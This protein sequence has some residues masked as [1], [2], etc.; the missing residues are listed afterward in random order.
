MTAS[1]QRR[2]RLLV[3]SAIGLTTA[4]LLASRYLVPAPVEAI[5]VR[6][7]T[8]TRIYRA[9]G[10]L[11]ADR[12][13][14]LAARTTGLVRAAAREGSQ[15]AA[16]QAVV[17]LDAIDAE[18]R[19]RAAEADASGGQF[20]L[21]EAR[22]AVAAAQARHS[23]VA[24]DLG[25]KRALSARGF[26]PDASLLDSQAAEAVARMEVLRAQATVARM[27][28]HMRASRF[29]AS[30][31]RA[32][33]GQFTLRSPISGIVIKQSR[34][35]GEIATP[36]SAILEIVDPG[37]LAARLNCDAS[38]VASLR[39]GQ[40]ARLGWTPFRTNLPAVIDDIGRHVD[41]ETGEV[42]VRV[43]LLRPPTHWAIGQ[44]VFAQL[45][46]V[47]ARAVLVVPTAFVVRTGSEAGV[48]VAQ[49]GRARWR[50]IA[51]GRIGD[52]VVEVRSGLIAG[53]TV[54]R[55]D[56]QFTWRPV[57]IATR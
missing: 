8:V 36:G 7:G 33:L 25:R 44:P 32:Q 6:A 37:S 29:R 23:A 50:P 55:P 11:D 54:L 21:D 16:Q 14:I 13:A 15:V 35:R 56:D 45:Q 51:L 17:R 52:T 12:R 41:P 47:E 34:R 1:S 46:L 40:I 28:Q 38:I 9:S 49:A 27:T 22:A 39:R 48:W 43:R 4:L 5:V 3:L 42:D 10:A 30:E 19:A 26:L 31:G 53:E 24:Q 20:A 2:T 18:S 57:R